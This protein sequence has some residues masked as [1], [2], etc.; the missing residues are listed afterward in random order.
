MKDAAEQACSK[1]GISRLHPELM[2]LIG[3]LR[4]RYSY[5]QNVLRHSVEC[6]YIA[7]MLAAE[8]KLNVRVARRAGFLH[9]IGKAVSHERRAA[10]AMIGG[11]DGEEVGRGA[12]GHQRDRRAPRR[13]AADHAIAHLVAAA[14]AISS[15]PPGRAAGD[16]RVVPE[17]A[18]GPREDRLLVPG[19]ERSFAIQ[20][21]RE[22]RVF[23]EGARIAD[24]DAVT[25]SRD[26]A[27]KIEEELTYPGQIK[28]TVIRETRA[29]EYAR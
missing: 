20:A 13:R 5:A 9:D 21:G 8:L 25:L 26:I 15:A 19:V 16:A 14:D 23:V 1:L 3:Q 17:S 28:V 6:G 12:D 24:L 4:Y 27:R 11:G 2:K 10:H 7:G 22:I 18:G 29:V